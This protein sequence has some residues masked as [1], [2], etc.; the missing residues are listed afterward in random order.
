MAQ[1]NWYRKCI[2]CGKARHKK[3]L[4][5]I[6]YDK[7]NLLQIDPEKTKH[8]RGIYVCPQLKCVLS[9]K[10]N[11][12]IEKSLHKE[13]NPSFYDVLIQQVEKLEH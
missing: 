13:I 3:E 6:V 9:A 4:L 2:G 12:G 8:G 1:P 7:N 5:R 11:R 10:Q